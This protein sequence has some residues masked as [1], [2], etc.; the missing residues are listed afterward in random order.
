M[1]GSRDDAP[2][3]AEPFFSI[4]SEAVFSWTELVLVGVLESVWLVSFHLEMGAC[5]R[6][7]AICYDGFPF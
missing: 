7:Y 4:H 6:P 5:A 1:R 2:G 3:T